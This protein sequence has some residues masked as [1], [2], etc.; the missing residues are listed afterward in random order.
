MTVSRILHMHFGKEGGAERFFVNLATAFGE[1][2]IKQRFIVRPGRVWENEIGGLGPML[3][4]EF[5]PYSPKGLWM[6]WKVHQIVRTWQPDVVMAWMSRSSKLLPKGAPAVKLTR[7]GDYPRHLKNFRNNDLI[8]ANAPGI[9]EACRGLGWR[10]PLAV[11]SNFAREVTIT[12]VSRATLDTPEDAFLVIGSG[13]FVNRK[14][15]DVLVKAVADIPD[16]WLWLVGEGE[17]RGELEALV[18]EKGMEGRTRFTGWVEEPMN[19]V[20]A[21][22]VFVMPSRH[23]P[24]G[25]VI[26]EAWQAD[27]PVVTTR[28]E[29]PS[30][31]VREGEDALFCEIDDVAG[32]IAAI[33]RLRSDPALA[34]R[35]R[36]EGRRRLD[37]DFRRD[38]VV[39]AYLD[40]FRRVQA[41]DVADLTGTGLAP[42]QAR[43]AFGRGEEVTA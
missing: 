38:A 36:R 20:A 8:V 2:G 6:R 18:R 12:P 29:G 26:L 39:D 7:L 37:A 10:R 41:G 25:N 4:S 23:E 11:V 22:N 27:V 21:G 33:N 9:A 16:A 30:W 32:T 42:G 15:F 3:Q 13:R 43:L 5:R 40:L 17:K 19:Y 34:E 24:L 14:G 35:L 1:R 28:S 31:F